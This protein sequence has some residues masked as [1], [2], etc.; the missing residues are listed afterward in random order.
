M[1]NGHRI[2]SAEEAVPHYSNMPGR[3]CHHDP[4]P[5][6]DDKEDQRERC[7]VNG[8]P[9]GSAKTGGAVA[10]EPMVCM[11]LRWREQS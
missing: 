9:F 4:L 7:N 10:E 6:D 3:D 11:T 2:R 1:V 5:G 8:W